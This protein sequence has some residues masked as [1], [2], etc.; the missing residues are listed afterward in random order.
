MELK[1]IITMLF[2]ILFSVCYGVMLYFKVKGNLLAAV[3][4]LIA[5]AEKTD[6]KGSEKM[7]Q[8]VSSLYA[9][10]PVPFKKLLTEERVQDIAQFVF[11]SMR[12]YAEEYKTKT[13]EQAKSESPETGDTIGRDIAIGIVSDLLEMTIEQ[14]A[15]Y[16]E[17]HFGITLEESATE[18]DYIEV[19]VRNVLN[20]V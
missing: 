1:E 8:V 9:M 17:T 19:I 2:I 5:I 10:I 15:E 14:M 11:D 4:E 12:K 16:A 13:E 7:A 20:K 18:K 6:L 3:S